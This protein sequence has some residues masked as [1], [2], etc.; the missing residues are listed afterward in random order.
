LARS[1]VLGTLVDNS[2]E[3]GPLTAGGGVVAAAV[4]DAS[5]FEAR[6]SV[7]AGETPLL[8][9]PERVAETPNTPGLTDFAVADGSRAAEKRCPGDLV[10][11]ILIELSLILFMSFVTNHGY[12]LIAD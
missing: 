12:K 1:C 7:S 8:L 2:S 11:A 6:C 4:E 9:C 5:A 10:R 3:L